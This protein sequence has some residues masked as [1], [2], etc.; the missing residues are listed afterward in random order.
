MW[1]DIRTLLWLQFKLT[2]AVFRG[3]Q[4]GDRLRALGLVSRL[5]ALLFTLPLFVLMGGAL[6]VGLILLTPRAAYELA[7][8]VNVGAGFIWLLLPASYS[9]QT[10]ERFEMSRLFAYPI[11][12]RSIVAGSTLIS[13][14]TM[15]GLWTAPLL[16]GEIVGLAWHQPLALPLIAL[17]ALPT[18][19]LLALSG[20]I[21]EDLFDLVAGDRRLRALVLT[22]LMLPFMFCWVIQYAVQ[23]ATDHFRQLPQYGE[24][25]I[26][27]TLE[28]LDQAKSLAE[29]L[30]ILSP[31][32][33]LI[34]LPTG[35]STAGMASAAAG[36]LPH[37][38][39]ML[40][41]WGRSLFYLGLSVAFV[42]ALLWVHAQIVRRLQRG[43]ALRVGTERV[44]TRSRAGRGRLPGPPSFWAL[45]RKDWL[46][47]QRS[48]LPK[49]LLFSAAL[50]AL[51][52][53]FAISR[54]PP[55]GLADIIPLA[56]ITFSTI[57]ISLIVNLGLTANYAGSV[58]REG[59]GTLALSAVDRR[60]VLLS[61]NLVALLF[62][63]GIYGLLT[64]LVALI[65]RAWV[66][67]PLGLYLGAC[68][69]IGGSPAYNLAA[70]LTPFRAQL[71]MSGKR[72]RGNLWGLLAWFVA[73]LPVLAL[74]VL[75]Y[76]YWRPGLVLTLPLGAAY[77]IALYLAT[78]KPL[79]RLLQ[80]REYEVLQAVGTEE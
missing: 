35:W 24:L 22:V 5:F 68:I 3:R 57:V 14:L 31:S 59:Y 13:L 63:L 42:T 67:I 75:P 53:V 47:L 21:M 55:K 78:L 30:E 23:F 26:R 38:G 19:A 43:A 46:Y 15:T 52:M 36:P 80:Q 62:V 37:A 48:P 4:V 79:A 73:A 12:F 69:Q 54:E 76:L 58:D 60:Q 17:G 49:R 18:F 10:I 27:E 71:Q 8:V 41:P 9:S 40:G 2:R 72:S 66:V 29:F 44:R 51:G 34:W 56:V 70:I 16:L 50:S 1:A 25:P 61:A 7:M 64:L 6:A 77:S 39:P 11:R 33:L 28:A 32:R 20:R 45:A 74:I 65:S